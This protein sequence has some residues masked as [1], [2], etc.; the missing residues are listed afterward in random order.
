MEVSNETS[1]IYHNALIIKLNV[2]LQTA[3]IYMQLLA[4]VQFVI[5]DSAVQ[6]ARSTYSSSFEFFYTYVPWSS[7]KVSL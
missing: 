6:Y 2:Q 3:V 1:D 4:A 7:L 5:S